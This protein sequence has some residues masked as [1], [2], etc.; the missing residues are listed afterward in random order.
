MTLFQIPARKRC[1][2][3]EI[4]DQMAEMVSL[5]PSGSA[6]RLACEP[7]DHF[8]IEGHEKP[9][10]LRHAL[11]HIVQIDRNQWNVTSR[12]NQMGNS[13]PESCQNLGLAARPFWKD[14]DNLVLIQ[15]GEDRLERLPPVRVISMRIA[16][17][18]KRVMWPRIPV[19]K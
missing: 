9:G 13:T 18:I 4:L 7:N 10:T 5:A 6:A 12:F 3:G 2:R 17:K 8:A 19:P 16:C 1:L 11:P 15:R 14:D